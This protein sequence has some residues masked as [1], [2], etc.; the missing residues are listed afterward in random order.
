MNDPGFFDVLDVSEQ[1]VIRSHSNSRT[2]CNHPRNL[3]D[4]RVPALALASAATLTAAG[5]CR[6]I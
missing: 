2:I 3:S 4:E 5:D 1:P 6:K